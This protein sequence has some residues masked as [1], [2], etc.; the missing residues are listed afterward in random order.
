MLQVDSLLSEPIGKPKEVFVMFDSL[1][2]HGLWS[3]RLLC[4]WDSPGKNTGVGCY[5]LLQGFFLTPGLNLGL[6]HC[7]QI[8]YHL[9][10]QESPSSHHKVLVNIYAFSFM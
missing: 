6:L 2:F 1:R 7:G 5:S 8:L 3:A 9:S 4:S 10:H